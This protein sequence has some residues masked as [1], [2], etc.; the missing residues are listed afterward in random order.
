M[1]YVDEAWLY[2]RGEKENPFLAPDSRLFQNRLS[3]MVKPLYDT[4]QVSWV[5]LDRLL[6][7]Q[8][9]LTEE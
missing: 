5:W 8:G 4:S 9:W 7:A 2:L 1:G 6:T 3:L